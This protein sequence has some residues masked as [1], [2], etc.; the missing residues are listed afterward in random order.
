MVEF[1][2]SDWFYVYV[3]QKYIFNNV[4]R[5]FS[6]NFWWGGGDS[7]FFVPVSP[8][9]SPAGTKSDGGGDIAKK[10]P[11]EAETAHL[12]QN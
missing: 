5:V 11:T 8:R 10:N 1:Q 7:K 12:M 4:T 2:T 9:R 6:L 3:S